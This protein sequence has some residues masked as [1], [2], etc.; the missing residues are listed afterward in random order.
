MK[1]PTLTKRIPRRVR[2]TQRQRRR[3]GVRRMEGRADAD[4]GLTSRTGPQPH[5][6]PPTPPGQRRLLLQGRRPRTM[7]PSPDAAVPRADSGHDAEPPNLMNPFDTASP[8]DARYY[9]ADRDFFQRL[10]P[11]VSEGAQVKFL[12]RVEAALA[13]VLAEYAVCPRE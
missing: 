12:A 4:M 2:I 13:Q 11:Y 7:P 9:L 3:G 6:T 10:R 5:H 8:L 1:E